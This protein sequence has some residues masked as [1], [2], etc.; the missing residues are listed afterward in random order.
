M[1]GGGHEKGLEEDISVSMMENTIWRFENALQI[2][3]KNEKCK[4]KNENFGQ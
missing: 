1:D 2:A 4:M 3:L